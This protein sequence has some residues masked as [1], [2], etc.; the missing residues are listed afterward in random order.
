MVIKSLRNT[1]QIEAAV[2]Q[3]RKLSQE[4][5]EAEK[6]RHLNILLEW[7]EKLPDTND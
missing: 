1:H 7:C 6:K 5:F 4:E 2:T 3:D